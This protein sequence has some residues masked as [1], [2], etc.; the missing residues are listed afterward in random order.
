MRKLTL[1]SLLAASLSPLILG[2]C[3]EFKVGPESASEL[4]SGGSGGECPTTIDWV[5]PTIAP[6]NN[7][8]YGQSRAALGRQIGDGEC[9]TLPD[10]Y[11]RQGHGIPFF[12]L[13][14]TGANADYVWGNLVSTITTQSKFA[15]GAV[16]GDVIQFRDAAFRWT[17]PNG[18][19]RTAS[20]AHHTAV[21]SAVSRDASKEI[22]RAHV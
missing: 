5:F 10:T 17:F 4:D 12:N 2:A 11:I 20:A 19:W 14:P 18:S 22:G 15:R 1:S 13:G 16:P 21:V 8:V 3:G 7:Y 9:A 6:L